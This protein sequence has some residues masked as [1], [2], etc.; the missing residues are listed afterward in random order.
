[1]FVPASF[2]FDDDRERP[3]PGCCPERAGLDVDVGAV[4]VQAGA[5]NLDFTVDD[6]L[7]RVQVVLEEGGDQVAEVFFRCRPPSAGG[8]E[9]LPVPQQGGLSVGRGNQ[10]LQ[11]VE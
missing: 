11:A 3:L 2:A 9:V 5:E 7:A 10:G 8:F 4:A 6:D 1:M